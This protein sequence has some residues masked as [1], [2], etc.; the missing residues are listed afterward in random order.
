LAWALR[1]EA[2]LK[3][4]QGRAERDRAICAA[5]EHRGNVGEIAE[6]AGIARPPVYEILKRLADQQDTA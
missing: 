2:R 6:A 5:F 3:M 4:E 1:A